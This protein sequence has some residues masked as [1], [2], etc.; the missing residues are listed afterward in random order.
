[1]DGAGLSRVEIMRIVNRYI[2][3]SGGYLGDFSYRSHADFYPEYCDLDIDPY[4][5]DGTTR[6]RFIAIL[7]TQ[8]PHNQARIIRGLIERCPVDGDGAPDTRT[9]EL[10][11]QLM[12]WARRL[13]GVVV[14][15]VAPKTTRQ[16]VALAIAD[17]ETLLRSSGGAPVSVDRVHTSLHA[18]LVGECTAIGVAVKED[19]TMAKL[20][21]LLRSNHPELHAASPATAKAQNVLQSFGQ[22]LDALNPIRNTA[23]LAHPTESLL[24]EAEAQLVI[25]AGRTILAYLDSRLSAPQ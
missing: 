10:R 19:F 21:K 1:M 2:G 22:A 11:D 24:E 5:L 17:I 4:E 18:Y 6:E 15:G 16:D 3:V 20:L 7:E 13:D 12:A 14:D 25:N 23:S 8:N 9:V